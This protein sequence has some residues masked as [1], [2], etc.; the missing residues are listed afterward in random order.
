MSNIHSTI[1]IKL[2]ESLS[3]DLERKELY[4]NH[5]LSTVALFGLVVLPL[6]PGSLSFASIVA[7]FPQLLGIPV[8]LAYFIAAFT[9]IGVE[10]LGLVVIKLA[11]RMRKFNHQAI[12]AG[13]EPA[14]LGQ[15]IAAAALYLFV[16]LALVV[17]LKVMPE[18]AVWALI[19]LACLGAIADWAF[20]LQGDQ[21]ER[22]AALRRHQAQQA[23]ERDQTDQIEQL[24]ATIAQL[25]NEA[26]D[27]EQR[28]QTE[29][30][31][32][33]ERVQYAKDLHAEQTRQ[34]DTERQQLNTEVVTLRAQLDALKSIQGTPVTSPSPEHNTDIN[35]VRALALDAKRTAKA[36]RQSELLHIL[37]TELNGQT[38][39]LLN[40]TDLAQRLN[41]TRQT[42]GKDIEELIA[43]QRVAINGHIEVL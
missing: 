28:H 35:T 30:Q 2:Q 36:Q 40:K 43:A 12:G 13:I 3:A 10:V 7:H 5:S 18:L 4:F 27:R 38:S 9:A 23:I 16:V 17:L 33:H 34:F 1:N 22:E 39:D 21:S 41:T 26:A 31:T 8:W 15:G 32:L 24:T 6:I 14:P 20:A 11:L 37:V 29:V 42:I 19:P 25:R